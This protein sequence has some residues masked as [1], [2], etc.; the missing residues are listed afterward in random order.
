MTEDAFYSPAPVFLV[1]GEAKGELA[2]D[3]LW[4]AVEESTLGLRT[5]EATFAAIGPGPGG[6]APAPSYV[7]GAVLDFGRRLQVSIGRSGAER[8]VFDGAVS[9]V[10]LHLAAGV[11]PKVTCFAED[12]LMR[13][14]MTRRRA[15]WERTTDADLAR[16][17]AE[18]HG[19]AADADAD[20]PTYDVVHQWNQSDLAFLR[21]R[22]RLVQADVWA[23]ADGLH[24]VARSKRR[25]EEVELSG[26]HDVVRLDVRADL[27]HQRTSVEVRGY[28]AGQRQ[29]VTATAG[30]DV[31]EAEVTGGRLG[32]DVLG[33]AFD[34]LPTMRS[35]DVPLTREEADGFATAEMLRRARSFVTAAGE[36]RGRPE[37]SVGSRVTLTA[38]A[39]PFDGD[40]WYV[41]R[42]RH[43][44]DL[45]DGHRTWFEAER[46]TLTEGG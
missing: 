45:E 13:F 7:D 18:R 23:D 19:M 37:L 25:G 36:V 5:L 28:D 38:V 3:V 33:K 16:A 9:A 29:A 6:V 17:V 1:D 43:T 11:L 30:K 21:D 10:E 14:R 39:P 4:L 22:A 24:F 26:E 42:V 12:A 8:E 27:A 44:Y 20:G 34:E 35:R 32:V 46:A 40:G 41:T 15:R 2:R 31:V